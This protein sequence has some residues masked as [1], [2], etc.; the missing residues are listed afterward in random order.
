MEGDEDRAGPIVRVAQSGP[1]RMTITVNKREISLPERFELSVEVVAP[2][3]VTVEMPPLGKHLGDL[4]IRDHREYPAE[5][6]EGGWR[7]RQEYRLD[8]F[9]AGEHT[10]P[11][12]TARFIDQSAGEESLVESEVT[13]NEFTVTVT[14]LLEGE[15]DP[16]EF[17]DLKGPVPL[18]ADQSWAW[19]LWVG[20]GVAGAVVLTI[21]GVRVLRGPNRTTPEMVIPPHEWALDKLRGLIDEQLVERGLV[22]EFYFRLS[23]IVRRYI[24][25]RFDLMAPERT[26]EEFMLEVRGSPKLPTEYRAAVGAFLQACD[27]VKFARHAPPPDEISGTLD[28]ARDFVVRSAETSPRQV[29]AA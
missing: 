12:L 17:R 10:V 11:E 29:T 5:P 18:P 24:E 19:I 26:T 28:A 23:M 3:G 2:H 6:V 13:V 4:A 7:R 20:G 25:R 16:P 14:S 1:M 27:T 9:V 15:A 22:H 8:A 21:V